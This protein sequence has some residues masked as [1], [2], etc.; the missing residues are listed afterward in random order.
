MLGRRAGPPAP[1][2]VASLPSSTLPMASAL[3]GTARTRAPK[4]KQSRGCSPGDLHGLGS[5]ASQQLLWK[6]NVKCHCFYCS[7][8]ST[9][10]SWGRCKGPIRA[11][12][13]FQGIEVPYFDKNLTLFDGITKFVQVFGLLSC[14]PAGGE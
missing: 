11:Y 10:K 1:W 9:G 6:S 12:V 3:L 14:V 8:L 2:K 7:V 4:R 5:M 13:P